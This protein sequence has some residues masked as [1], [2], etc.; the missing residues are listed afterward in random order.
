MYVLVNKAGNAEK[1]AETEAKRDQL[2]AL[3]YVEV[4]KKG[5]GGRRAEQTPDKDPEQET[6][7]DPEQE[8]EQDPEQE[9]ETDEE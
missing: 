6:E 5:R 2:L 8:T 1:H 3:G 9:T 7:Q 4:K